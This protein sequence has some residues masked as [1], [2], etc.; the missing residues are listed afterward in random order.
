MLARLLP[1]VTLIFAVAFGVDLGGALLGALAAL[2][3]GGYPAQTAV[4]I[5]DRLKLWA[6][7]AAL[8][9]SLLNF[10]SIEVGLTRWQPTLI[11]RE[12]GYLGLAFAGAFS[13]YFVVQSIAGR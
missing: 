9:G 11:L 12:F 10:K 2:L 8:G 6:A 4:D 1:E 5:G 7:A 3:T 13:A